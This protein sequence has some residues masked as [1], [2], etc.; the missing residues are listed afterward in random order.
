VPT[1][2]EAA[3]EAATS[4]STWGNARAGVTPKDRIVRSTGVP[5]S[6]SAMPSVVTI[7]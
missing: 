3:A 1:A 6:S 7:E 4:T 5:V 2:T